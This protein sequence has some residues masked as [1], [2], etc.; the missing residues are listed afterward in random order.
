ML[1]K[2]I[3]P[4]NN[5]NTSLL[6]FKHETICYKQVKST[7]IKT[8]SLHTQRI[9]YEFINHTYKFFSKMCLNIFN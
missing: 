2:Q 7:I 5:I 9:K 1:K 3:K 8:F 6:N 4:K